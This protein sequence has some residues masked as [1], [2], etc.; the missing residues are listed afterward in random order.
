M[1]LTLDLAGHDDTIRLGSVLGETLAGGV[2]ALLGPLGAGKTTMVHGIAAGLGMPDT[3]AVRSPSFALVRIHELGRLPLVH[4]D[5]YRLGDP[6]EL[7]ELGL[8]DWMRG[9]A[10]V[11]VE[12]ADRFPEWMEHASLTVVLEYRDDGT[13]RARLTSHCGSR[14][15]EDLLSLVQTRFGTAG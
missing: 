5:F 3:R 13:R 10:V 7:V 12:W 2:V 8:D 4:V 9:N 6:D 15:A 1:A 11:A 14:D